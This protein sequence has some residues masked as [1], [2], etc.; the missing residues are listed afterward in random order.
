M[1]GST[2]SDW[3]ASICILWSWLL[4]GFLHPYAACSRSRQEPSESRP[5]DLTCGGLFRATTW[6]VW[7]RWDTKTGWVAG[8]DGGQLRGCVQAKYM[9]LSVSWWIWTALASA[10]GSLPLLCPE[11]WLPSALSGGNGR[12]K[13]W[14][15]TLLPCSSICPDTWIN[16]TWKIYQ[17][18]SC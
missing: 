17:I 12:G 6:H 9:V 15:G 4:S 8:K 14:W 10:W 18:N 3:L 5:S 7:W 13:W 11:T 16:H 1:S 2:E